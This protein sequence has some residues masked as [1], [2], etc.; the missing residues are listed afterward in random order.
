MPFTWADQPDPHIKQQAGLETRVGWAVHA[1]SRRAVTLCC[2]HIL[3]G[4]SKPTVWSAFVNKAEV[5]L[6]GRLRG[7]LAPEEFTCPACQAR[8][9]ALPTGGQQLFLP[10]P[11]SDPRFP[12]PAPQPLL[13]RCEAKH[14]RHP[15]HLQAGH[16]G[17]HRNKKNTWAQLALVTE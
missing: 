5:A 7:G 10:P 8:D 3:T 6:A 14:G 13:L 15:C 9:R 16:P 11:D 1:A 12:S 4:H 2:G 17:P